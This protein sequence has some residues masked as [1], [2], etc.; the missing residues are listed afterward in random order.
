MLDM[1]CPDKLLEDTAA[2]DY[3]ILAM[4][5]EL[6]NPFI[7]SLV[8]NNYTAMCELME[9]LVKRGYRSFAFVGTARPV[10]WSDARRRGFAA[11]LRKEGLRP[12][13]YRTP[14]G[15][16]RDDFTLE[17]RHLERWLRRL[18]HGTAVFAAHDER[19]QQVTTAARRAGVVLPDDIALLGVDDDELICTTAAPTIS[20]IHV[21]SEDEGWRFAKAMSGL[22]DGSHP[23]PIVRTCHTRVI[24]RLSTDAFAHADPFVAKAVAY[25]EKHLAEPLRGETLATAANCSLRTLQMRFL[26]TL[27]HT[28]KDGLAFLRQ[29][30]AVKLLRET[31]LPIA[32]VARRCG[33]ASNAYFSKTEPVPTYFNSERN[34]FFRDFQRSVNPLKVTAIII[35]SI[36]QFIEREIFCEPYGNLAI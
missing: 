34:Y 19:A 25:A 11:R 28:I 20:S 2:K 7:K 36:F 4:D 3:P 22:L 31:D 30:A 35:I 8:V 17:S 1:H 10:V 18:P 26:K 29:D 21:P 9:E 14:D 24:T 23:T 32:D 5:R 27:G 33:F 15:K 12:I 16:A 13:L 6:D